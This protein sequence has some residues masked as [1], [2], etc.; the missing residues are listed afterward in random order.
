LPAIFGKI[1]FGQKLLTN[2]LGTVGP[3]LKSGLIG[4]AFT[5]G[6]KPRPTFEIAERKLEAKVVANVVLDFA[7]SHISNQ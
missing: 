3:D 4:G 5:G 7:G 6:D 1:R 2:L